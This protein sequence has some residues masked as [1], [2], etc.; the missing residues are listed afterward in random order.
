[1]QA[2]SLSYANLFFTGKPFKPSLMFGSV[3][4]SLF[5][6]GAV[7]RCSTRIGFAFI[8]KHY[9]SLKKPLSDKHSSLFCLFHNEEKCILALTFDP[10]V[11]K[12]FY[13]SLTLLVNKLECLT[14]PSPFS[15][16]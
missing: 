3:A 12:L 7:A 9:A 5:Y 8:P 11:I 1:M 16:V 4:G 14:P 13:L 2:R 10:N 6:C 15:Q